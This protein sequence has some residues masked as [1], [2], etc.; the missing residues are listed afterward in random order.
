MNIIFILL[1]TGCLSWINTSHSSDNHTLTMLI[2]TTIQS[3]SSSIIKRRSSIEVFYTTANRTENNISS[4]MNELRPFDTV[5]AYNIIKDGSSKL[6]KPRS[7][8]FNISLF[9]DL[10]K[11]QIKVIVTVVIIISFIMFIIAIFRFK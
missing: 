9:L 10:T 4:S 2:L 6:R 7:M 11:T 5:H 8:N 3:S 1:L